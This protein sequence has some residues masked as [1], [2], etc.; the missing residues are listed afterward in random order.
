MISRHTGL[1]L[2]SVLVGFPRK[3]QKDVNDS[4][5]EIRSMVLTSPTRDSLHL[6]LEEL[7]H[8]DSGYHPVIDAFNASLFLEDTLPNIQPFTFIEV[9]RI[10]SEDVTPITIDQNIGIANMD[11][12]TRYTKLVMNSEEYRL[13]IRGSTGLHQ[14]GLRKI[15]VD[16]NEVVTL[17][18]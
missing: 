14:K 15:N 4:R 12:F 16:Y 13:A 10:R 6:R 1:Y 18:G 17:K 11:Q 2:Y 5:L 8:N 3:A 7:L 9:P